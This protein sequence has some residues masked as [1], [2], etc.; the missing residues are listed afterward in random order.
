MMMFDGGH[1][2]Y[3]TNGTL[4]RSF[5]DVRS[6]QLYTFVGNYLHNERQIRKQNRKGVL[7][8]NVEH[9]EVSTGCPNDCVECYLKE[10]ERNDYSV[11]SIETGRK[12]IDFG[13]NLGISIY[14]FVGGE[15]IR[16]RTVPLIRTL[17][18]E[19]P[20]EVFYCCTNGSYISKNPEGVRDIINMDN[21]SAG[22]SIDGFKETNDILRGNGSFEDTINSATYLGGEKC[23]FGG[24]VT[25]RIDNW[26]EST[27]RDFIDYLISKKFAYILFSFADSLS[28]GGGESYEK[29][30]SSIAKCAD[31]PIFIY[32]NKF[33]RDFESRNPK[34]R[35]RDIDVT[36]NGDIYI[37][38]RLRTKAGDLNTDINKIA[39]SEVWKAR[40]EIRC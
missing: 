32:T 12:A 24:V 25:P 23:F 2:R 10:D 29:A 9:I 19:N 18:S 39:D 6:S 14:D 13:K 38:R 11:M 35:I 4:Y 34:T 37:S 3:V 40:F 26:E 33:G 20:K 1:M 17:V 22:L 28:L 30:V 16:N 8:P 5:K 21:F 36:K 7:I 27:S 15:T 31:M